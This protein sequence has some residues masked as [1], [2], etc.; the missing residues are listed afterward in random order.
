[1]KAVAWVAGI[2]GIIIAL[3][4]VI[5]RLRETT[6]ISILGEHEPSTFLILGILFLV[7]GLWL[8]VL[9]LQAKK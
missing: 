5:D 3:V 2:F 1:M 7:I 4:G 8:A 9:E 6:T